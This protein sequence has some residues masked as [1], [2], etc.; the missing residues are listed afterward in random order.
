LQQVAAQ[1]QSVVDGDESAAA[2]PAAGV[3]ATTA[4]AALAKLQRVEASLADVVDNRTYSEG[5]PWR[6]QLDDLA[7]ELEDFRM[8]LLGGGAR[9]W[10]RDLAN[11]SDEQIAAARAWGLSSV[12]TRLFSVT[13]STFSVIFKF[14]L[15]GCI[16]VLALYYFLADGAAM[17]QTCMRLSPLDDEY[18]RQLMREFARTSRAVV[19]ATL[20]SAAAQA[21]LAGVGFW[22]AGVG[23]VFLLSTLTLVLALIPFVGA[24]AVWLP[25]C[26]WLYFVEERMAASILLGVYGFGIISM[27]DNVVKPLVLH[28]QSQMHPLVALLSI[29]GGVQAL[30]PVGILVGPMLVAFLQ[31][32]LKILNTELARMR[33]SDESAEPGRAS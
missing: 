21:V 11:P 12:Q 19:L 14:V 1:L 6:L 15:G 7:L 28:G 3:S 29:L 8:Q 17:V 27:A 9:A 5:T 31:A 30:G 20:L 13:Q 23:N 4:A 24:G 25:V 16:L 18:E 33:S 10:L 22:V 26:L 32:L 2:G